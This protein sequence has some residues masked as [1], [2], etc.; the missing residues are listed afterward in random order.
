TADAAELGG[1][2]GVAPVVEAVL[3]PLALRVEPGELVGVRADQATAERLVRLLSARCGPDE[4]GHALLDGA[5]V[6]AL[7]VERWRSRML[8]APHRAELFDGTVAWNLATP[9]ADPARIPEA[10]DAAACADILDVLPDGLDTPVGE[11]GMRLSGGQRQRIALARAYAAHPP[12]LVLHEPTTSVDAATEQAIAARI[13]GVRGGQTTIL[14][15]SSPALLSVC[16]RVVTLR[17]DA[18]GAA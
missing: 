4:A 11:G 1:K 7:G 2:D 13:R 10:L 9:G 6:L 3:P 12:V 14:V 18:A 15:T 5:P 16:E 8:V 17:G